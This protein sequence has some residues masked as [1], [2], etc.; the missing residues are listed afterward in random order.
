MFRGFRWQLFA[1]AA[2]AVLFVISLALR[3]SQT[4][5][6]NPTPESNPQVN[7][8]APTSTPELVIVSNDVAPTETAPLQ[9]S[10]TTNNTF[11]EGLVGRV[12]RLNPLYAS[13]NSV[14]QDIT[15]LIFEGLVKTNN[16]GEPTPGL[17]ER[18]II[19]S[20][21][22]EYTVFLRQDVLWQDGIPFTANDVVYTMS[23]LRSPEFAG[24]DSL[25]AFWRTVETQRLGDHL[26][27]FRLT[28]PLGSFLEQ[29][30]IGILPEHALN[31]T[32]AAQ[33]TSH[34]FNL[35][36]IGTGPYQIESI[37]THTDGAIHAVNLRVAPTYR[38]R[39]EGQAEAF[40]IDRVTFV[41]VSTFDEALSLLT[42]G[43]IDGLAS[44][45]RA[46]RSDL[47]TAANDDDLILNNQLDATLGVL[48]FNW[49]HEEFREQRMRIALQS[50]LDREAIVNFRMANTA[51]FAN[52]PLLPNSWAY[53]PNLAWEPYDLNEAR[54]LLTQ[55]FARIERVSNDEAEQAEQSEEAESTE[56]VTPE[57]QAPS[58][59]FAFEILTLDDPQSVSLA[60]EIASQW[61]QLNL[62]VTVDA[63]DLETYHQRLTAHEFDTAIV[64]Y[65]LGESADP[66][67]Y[68]F[69]HEGQ[70]PNGLNYGGATDRR[71]SELLERARRDPFGVNRSIDYRTF[72]AVF[73]ERAIAI[74][75]YYPIFTYATSP[76]VAN[77]QLGFIGA[78]SDRFRTIGAW[79]MLQ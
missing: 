60:Q 42:S 9:A 75:L 5:A 1:L 49:E 64:E 7:S 3:Q 10:S 29:L 52:S 14:D 76:D 34:P 33:L 67:V 55:A 65:S 16:F 19:S 23:I 71:I 54:Q 56:E 17:A 39:P 36:P 27:R 41:L 44:A 68:A 24:A 30:T 73:A 21:G 77:L 20:D 31:G 66:D 63:V 15:S 47:F 61:S 51:V 45:N 8:L 50:A 25:G 62:T 11:R 70:Y 12:Q 78:R 59:L 22:L 26:I 69:W 48:I 43:Q 79:Y 32:S 2:A 13:L 74:P 4:P 40:A 6:P 53:L 38:Q 58:G 46:N 37:F 72:Q 35:T 18:W 57:V 28:Q